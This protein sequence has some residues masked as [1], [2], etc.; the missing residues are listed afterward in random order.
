MS[1]EYKQYEHYLD[2][3]KI[4]YN[5]ESSQQE[6]LDKQLLTLSG[7]SLGFSITFV[8]KVFPLKNAVWP[9]LSIG[10]WVAFFITVLFTIISFRCSIKTCREYREQIDACYEEKCEVPQVLRSKY[11]KRIDRCNGVAFWAFMIGLVLLIL[12]AGINAIHAS[13]GGSVV[14]DKK[15]KVVDGIIPPPLPKNI[16]KDNSRDNK[17]SNSQQSKSKKEES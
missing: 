12:F 1:D 14:S 15:E 2:T 17:K 4:Y 11:S 16:N 6:S 7:L 8:E 9:Y 10:S 5:I 13:K 3:R